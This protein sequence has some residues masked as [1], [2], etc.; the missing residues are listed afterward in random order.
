MK[1]LKSISRNDHLFMRLFTFL[2]F[3]WIVTGSLFLFTANS[4]AGSQKTG[5]GSADDTPDVV[6]RVNGVPI[7]RDELT[8]QVDKNLQKYVKYGMRKPNDGFVKKLRQDALDKLIVAELF[9]QE[10]RTI[11]FDDLESK[12]SKKL[13]ELKE[14]AADNEGFDPKLAKQMLQRKILIDEYLVLNELK[15]PELPE[16]VIKDY[17]EK[18]KQN[19]LRK[20]S[21]RTRHILVEIPE[22][23]KPDEKVEARRKIEEARKLILD[24]KSFNEVAIEYSECNSA[25]GGGELGYN[26][27]GYMPPLYDE[28]AFSQKIG[29]LSEV[30]ETEHGFHIVEVVDR[31]PAGIV[32]YD[33]IKGF[34]GKYL[35]NRHAKKK[36]TAHVSGLKEK[37]KV[38]IYL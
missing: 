35:N 34:I 17:Y 14:Q 22:D 25:S 4:H 11:K 13:D 33:E 36:M 29:E 9:Y 37:A 2:G 19:F 10:A 1:H 6:A 26:E 31:K 28:I 24:E 15:D 38:E 3:V 21:A 5:D 30:I 16:K 20:E 18:N 23:A 7:T 27:R 12:V 32:P 8:P